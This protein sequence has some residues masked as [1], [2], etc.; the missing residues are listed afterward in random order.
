MDQDMEV[1]I[2]EPNEVELL[3]SRVT[4]LES[5]LSNILKQLE[6]IDNSNI[7]NNFFS[8]RYDRSSNSNR[9]DIFQS[10]PSNPNI[11]F[12]LPSIRK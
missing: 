12:K 2:T 1:E 7:S 8:D 10:K 6:S 4:Y 3:K 11:S 5:Q 9:Y